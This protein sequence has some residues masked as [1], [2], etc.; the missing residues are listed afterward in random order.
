MGWRTLCFSQDQYLISKFC[1]PNLADLG[2]KFI[3]INQSTLI[4]P[5]LIKY[6]PFFSL[7]ELLKGAKTHIFSLVLLQTNQ[8]QD[9]TPFKLWKIFDPLA[10]VGEE[11]LVIRISALI[12]FELS[13]KNSVPVIF[14]LNF[15]YKI[16]YPKYQ[17]P[18]HH[19]V[20]FFIVLIH[21]LK[22]N[23]SKSIKSKPNSKV[24]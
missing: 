9:K 17:Y 4:Q 22:L 20:Y 24:G 15:P 11:Y 18:Q 3:E 19:S 8:I 1:L 7:F 6:C 10:R 2:I 14:D 13:Y 21:S 23:K 12:C 5:I 16:R